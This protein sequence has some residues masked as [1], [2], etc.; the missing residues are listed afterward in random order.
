MESFI[1]YND[2]IEDLLMALLHLMVLTK[3]TCFL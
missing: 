3:L 2:I 1:V